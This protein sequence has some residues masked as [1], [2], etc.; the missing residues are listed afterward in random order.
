MTPLSVD[1]VC[2]CLFLISHSV[3][4]E[5]ILAHA[6]ELADPASQTIYT[7]DIEHDELPPRAALHVYT[8]KRLGPMRLL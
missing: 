6:G 1:G 3:P 5:V 4:P 2:V 8:Y 7:V